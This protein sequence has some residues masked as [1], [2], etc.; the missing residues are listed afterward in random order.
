MLRVEASLDI[1]VLFIQNRKIGLKLLPPLLVV[2]GCSLKVGKGVHSLE[3]NDYVGFF[4]FKAPEN[5]E[6]NGLINGRLNAN[7]I[8][9]VVRVVIFVYSCAAFDVSMDNV[10][11]FGPP[12]VALILIWQS[13]YSNHFPVRIE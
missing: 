5:P 4:D 8:Q 3:V 12:G 10:M 6:Y 2:P 11:Y 7:D 9:D 13:R 1:L